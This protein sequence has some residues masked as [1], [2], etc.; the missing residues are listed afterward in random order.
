[1]TGFTHDVIKATFTHRFV[2][3]A[4]KTIEVSTKHMANP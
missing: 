3:T 1:M 4:N 2:Q